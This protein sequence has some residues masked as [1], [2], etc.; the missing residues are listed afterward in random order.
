[1]VR[2]TFFNEKNHPVGWLFGASDVTRLHFSFAKIMVRLGPALAGDSPP[3]CRIV[4]F[5]S[6]SLTKKTTRLGGFLEL[7][8]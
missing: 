7:V 5:E 6:L 8:T 3:D 1:M 4:W 2:V